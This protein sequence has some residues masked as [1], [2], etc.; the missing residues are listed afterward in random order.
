MF[1]WAAVLA[2]N[3]L[4]SFFYSGMETGIYV[5]NKIR[6]ELRA[7][8]GSRSAYHLHRMLR[9]PN[10]LLVTLLIG[11]NIHN[12]LATF[13]VSA[14]FL[15]GG[16]GEHAE[17]YALAVSTPLLF[18]FGDSISKNVFQRT[19]ETNVYRLLW[20]LRIAQGLFIVTGLNPLIRLFGGGLMR[21]LGRKTPPRGQLGHEGLAAVLAEGQASGALTYSQTRMADRVMQLER[22]RLADV[23]QPMEKVFALPAGISREEF[24]RRITEHN[25]S[26]M[27]MLDADNQVAGVV[28][29]YDVLADEA[30]RPPAEL[31]TPPLILRNEQRVNEALYNLQRAR[32]SLAVVADRHARHVGIITVKDLVEEIVGELEA[33]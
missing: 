13:A 33:W 5:I 31:M 20:L 24:N 2:G 7:E 1:I 28:D 26:R 23:L 16:A 11:N 4:M 3:L 10:S 21:L 27:P 14:M 8:S 18:V 19:A 25:Y 22:V 15:L 6:V 29:I 30:D 12:Y 32:R 17:W 9:K